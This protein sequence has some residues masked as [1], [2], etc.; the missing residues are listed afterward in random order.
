MKKLNSLIPFVTFSAILV[1]VLYEWVFYQ[2]LV[3][4]LVDLP[5]ASDYLISA[6][7]WLPFLIISTP[8]GV[9]LISWFEKQPVRGQSPKHPKWMTDNPFW[10]II[11][12]ICCFVIFFLGNYFFKPSG[13]LSWLLLIAAL[14][15][16]VI[17]HFTSIWPWIP[18]KYTPLIISI[19]IYVPPIII[20]LA[21]LAMIDAE[22]ILRFDEGEYSLILEDGDAINN[23]VLVRNLSAGMLVALP[24][25]R[26]IRFIQWSAIRSVNVIRE[27]L[28]QE[29]RLCRWTGYTCYSE[30][31][32]EPIASE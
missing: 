1:S 11:L 13:A 6:V 27:E 12:M 21:W 20:G 31:M 26:S 4:D 30:T 16:W 7:R 32:N 14:A 24:D 15:W 18:R 25:E 28:V 9:L 17:A 3:P 10:S 2:R 8:I 22:E 23:A 19:W 5:Q 29:N